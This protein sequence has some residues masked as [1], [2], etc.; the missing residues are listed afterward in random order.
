[1]NKKDCLIFH[2]NFDQKSVAYYPLSEP[3]KA[4]KSSVNLVPGKSLIL[5]VPGGLHSRPVSFLFFLSPSL[6]FL[7]LPPRL[8]VSLSSSFFLFP[9]LSLPFLPGPG[10]RNSF[11]NVSLTLKSYS[12][13]SLVVG[14]E[15]CN[16]PSRKLF[17][18]LNPPPKKNYAAHVRHHSIQV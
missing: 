6:V 4:P 8:L 9:P 17:C 12:W 13:S 7:P 2:S 1:M 15:G 14:D 3:V 11:I 10:G 18:L 5:L 16:G